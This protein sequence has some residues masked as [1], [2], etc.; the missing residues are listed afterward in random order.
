MAA[1]YRHSSLPI[2]MKNSALLFLLLLMPFRLQAQGAISVEKMHRQRAFPS[3][4]PAGNY[5]GITPINDSIYAVVDDKYPRDGFHL[6]HIDIDSVSGK[7]RKVTHLEFVGNN[8]PSRDPEGIVYCPKSRTFFISGEKDNQILE[9]SLTGELTGRQ[10]AVPAFFVKARNN[11]GLESLAYNQNAKSFWTTSESALP[12]DSALQLH[13]QSFSEDLLPQ[14]E[15]IYTMDK[16]IKQKRA[17]HYAHGVSEI[18]ALDDGR[19]LVLE[20]E[21]FV[22]K[23]RIGAS[24]ICKLFL[25]SNGQKSLLCSWRTRLNLTRRSFANYEGMCL[26]PRLTNGNRVLILLSDSQNQNKGIL[27]DRFRTIVIS[28]I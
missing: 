9:Y 7:I 5:S 3:S 24:V 26:G 23:Q 28:G 15:I 17:R 13:I 19:L 25:F 27:K 18:T 2:A 14:K 6:F 4:V 8:N 20:R 11:K 1:S 12:G 21:L 10:L 16:P 22:P